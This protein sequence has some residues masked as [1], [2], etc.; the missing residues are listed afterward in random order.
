LIKFKYKGWIDE[1]VLS[2]YTYCKLR[3]YQISRIE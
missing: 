3:D 1:I 2:G